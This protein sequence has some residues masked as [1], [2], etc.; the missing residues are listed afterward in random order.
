MDTVGPTQLSSTLTL[1]S[2]PAAAPQWQVGQR[3]DAIVVSLISQD[4]VA[5]QIG[6]AMLEARGSL[7]VGIGQRLSL[8]VVQTGN[9]IM[10]RIVGN[11]NPADVMIAAGR[12]GSSQTVPTLTLNNPPASAAQWQVGQR[13]D[14]VV[15]ALAGRDRVTLQIGNVML[16]ARGELAA[17]VG[18]RLSLEVARMDNQIVLRI[19]SSASQADPVME[20]FRSALPQQLPLQE[21]FTRFTEILA[22]NPELTPTATAILKVLLQQLPSDQT[23]THSGALKQSLLESGQFLEHELGSSA[24]ASSLNKDIKANLLRLLAELV[25]SGANNNV[26]LTR[27]VEGALARIQLHQLSALTQEQTSIA[28][29]GELPIRHGNQIDVLHLR[30]EKDSTKSADADQKSWYTWLSLDLKSLGPLHA[31]IAL[32]DRSISTSF[33]AES[34]A[35]ANLINENL[36]YLHLALQQ[37]GLEVKEIQ[38]RQGRPPFPAPDRLPKGLLDITA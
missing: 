3:L 30:I 16:E 7:E 33:W 32:S 27:H 6:A 23:V 37:A 9:Q 10:L 19:T 24:Q 35:T 21:A 5:L 25:Q 15:A 4:R 12:S 18:Q 34:N 28:W 8:E 13:L 26:D 31:K 14:A 38:C 36:S 11:Q 1:A 22:S 20:A 29:A 17:A 2:S